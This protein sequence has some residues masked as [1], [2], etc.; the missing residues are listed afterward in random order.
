VTARV[1]GLASQDARVLADGIRQMLGSG[2]VVFGRADG[3]KASILVAVTDDLK[4]S[5]LPATS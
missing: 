2:V 4:P 3:D 1:D 5:C